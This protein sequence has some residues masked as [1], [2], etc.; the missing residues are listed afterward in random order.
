MCVH[1]N[2]QLILESPYRRTSENIYVAA[3]L[4]NLVSK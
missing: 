1:K 2:G 3:V 4:N